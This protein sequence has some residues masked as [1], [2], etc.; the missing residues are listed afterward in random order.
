MDQYTLKL[1]QLIDFLTNKMCDPF[2]FLSID[3]GSLNFEH[4]APRIK[5]I[6]TFFIHESIST[7]LTPFSHW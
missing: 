6:I 4:Y 1:E 2:F 5:T 7:I 3:T